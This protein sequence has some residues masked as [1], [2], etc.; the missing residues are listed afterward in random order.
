MYASSTMVTT[1]SGSAATNARI[2]AAGSAVPVGLLGL[3]RYTARVRAG[4]RRAHRGQVVTQLAVDRH[5]FHPC[6]AQLRV[7]R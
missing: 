7:V 6:T 5:E 4:H 3:H 2:C 1:L